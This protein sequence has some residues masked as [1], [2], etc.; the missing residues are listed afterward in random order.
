MM[1]VVAGF[2]NTYFI[3][4][5][6]GTFHAKPIY[7]IHGIMYLLWIVLII[8]QPL[9]VR[10][11]LTNIHKKIGYAGMSLAV[12]MFFAGIAIAVVS[13]KAGIASGAGTTPLSFFIVPLTDMAFFGGFITI[14]LLNLRD[15]ELHKRLILL[16]TLAILP[17]AFGRIIG[18]YGV[19]VGVALFLQESILILGIL[20]DVYMRKKIHPAY[21]WGG[22]AVV[23]VHLIRFPLGETETWIS[24]ANWIL[25]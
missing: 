14:A 9:L 20:Y 12:G 22:T 2:M 15:S 6:N 18:I 4:V 24:I 21:I 11:R 17:A 10:L 13:A 16:A 3:P 5:T 8:S 1:Y 23:I 19:N 7:H 25:N